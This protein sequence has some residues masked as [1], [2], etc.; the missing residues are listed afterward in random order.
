[1]V[2]VISSIHRRRKVL[3]VARCFVW[4]RTEAIREYNMRLNESDVSDNA[5]GKIA[6]KVANDQVQL[7]AQSSPILGAK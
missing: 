5:N 1:M 2:D 3:R 7:D 6:A 4:P